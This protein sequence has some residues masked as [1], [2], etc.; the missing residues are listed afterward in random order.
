MKGLFCFL[1]LLFTCSQCYNPVL[2]M[3][4]IGMSPNQGTYHD[5]VQITSWIQKY[6]PGTIAIPLDFN[7]GIPSQQPLWNQTRQLVSFIQSIVSNNSSF[8]NGFHLIGHSQGGLLTRSFLE[9][10]DWHN[11]D[12]YISIAGVQMGYYGLSILPNFLVKHSL[13]D[14]TKI[15]YTPPFQNDWSVANFWRGPESKENYVTNNTF[16]PVLN[17]EAPGNQTARFKKNF[18][19]VNNTVF[20]GS[21][22]DATLQPWET[23]LFGFYD[24][25]A[26][27]VVPMKSQMVYTK[28]LFGLQTM[29]R[30]GRLH[31]IEVNGMTHTEWLRDE[32]KF[33][34]YILDWLT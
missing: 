28:D 31:M 27:N 20:L 4:G 26:Q 32:N 21:S 25:S 17:G 13:E 22:S 30:A 10:A 16:L 34:T 5:F 33:V 19:R 15:L 6:H 2:M 14:I 24:E 18:L 12:S 1:L 7:N 11:V 9:N 29:D 8:R 3:H 23:S